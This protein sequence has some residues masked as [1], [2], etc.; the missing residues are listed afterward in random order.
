M[1]SEERMKVLKMVSDGILSIEEADKLLDALNEQKSTE[2]QDPNDGFASYI[3]GRKAR[4]IR[5][6]VSEATT[7]KKIVNLRL[8]SKLISA[9]T[10]IGSKFA[11]ELEGID[12]NYLL[13][14]LSQDVFGK[15]IDV[16]DEEDGE[17]VEIFVE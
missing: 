8:P 2:P 9:G 17:H 5:V 13:D 15:I 16:V 6:V 12:T 4:W 14:A 3:P 7:G 1:S 10:K 11:P